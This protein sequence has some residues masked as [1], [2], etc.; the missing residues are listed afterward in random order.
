MATTIKVVINNHMSSG[1]DPD[2]AFDLPVVMTTSVQ[3][4]ESLTPFP[5][6]YFLTEE[7]R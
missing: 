1:N 7:V 4:G 2:A 3:V 6:P 5:S